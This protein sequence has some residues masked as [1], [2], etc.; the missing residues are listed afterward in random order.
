VCMPGAAITEQVDATHYKGTVKS[1]VGPAVMSFGG[2]IEVLDM[3]VADKRLQMLGKGADKSGSSASMNLTA[4][5]EAG[6][7]PGHSVLVGQATVVVSG[8]LAQFG[9]R[10]LV[11][12][13]DAMLTQ[14]AGNFRNAAAAVPVAAPVA[15]AAPE[16]ATA[17]TAS[18]AT[19]PSAAPVPV[20]KQTELNALGLMWTIV[21][22]WF[23]GLF[24][25]K[26]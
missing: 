12:V 19:A 22:G 18:P 1:K 2:D 14:F 16:A 4:H 9:S 21:K 20:P 15:G 23:A 8:K 10:L 24:G 25:K 13:S 17:T 7:A 3:N 11:P 5:L 6:D 26:A